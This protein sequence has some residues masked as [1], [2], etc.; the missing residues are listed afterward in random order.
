[1]PVRCDSDSSRSL[2]AHREVIP[3]PVFELRTP[4][5]R[6]AVAVYER[7]RHHSHLRSPDVS[8]VRKLP[9]Q[10]PRELAGREESC[11]KRR[12]R[13]NHTA[14]TA[15]AAKDIAEVRRTPGHGRFE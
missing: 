12:P 1:M 11:P 5:R 14:Q 10:A 9:R 2:I 4:V 15:K 3:S 7:L 13:A 8:R 6:T